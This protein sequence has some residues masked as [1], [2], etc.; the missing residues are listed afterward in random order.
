V[1]EGLS[2]TIF[3]FDLQANIEQRT[4]DEENSQSDIDSSE[5]EQAAATDD[6]EGDNIDHRKAIE[7]VAKEQKRDERFGDLEHILAKLE[8]KG[9]RNSILKFKL[10]AELRAIV[11]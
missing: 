7:R 6:E 9:A 3:Q 11:N 1:L 8:Q 10:M 4:E 5:S 2:R